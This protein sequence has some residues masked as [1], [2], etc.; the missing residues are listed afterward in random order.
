MPSTFS[1]FT[2]VW[3]VDFEFQSSE[4]ERPK[5]IC[6]VAHELRSGKVRPLWKD[7]LLR[8]SNPPYSVE[9]DSLFVAYYA[10]AEMSCHL[11]L[12]CQCRFMFWIFSRSFE[13]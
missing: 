11:A 10:S 8:L 13:I 5:P 12:G 3:L 4:G 1:D 9:R 7:D 2:E 6:L